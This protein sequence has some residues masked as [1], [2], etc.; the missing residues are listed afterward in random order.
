MLSSAY[1][2]YLTVYC[3]LFLLKFF[4]KANTFVC[5]VSYIYFSFVDVYVLWPVY[6]IELS[7]NRSS[8]KEKF[9]VSLYMYWYRSG[10][11]QHPDEVLSS[12][13]YYLKLLQLYSNMLATIF[14]LGLKWEIWRRGQRCSWTIDRDGRLL[15]WVGQSSVNFWT[16]TTIFIATGAALFCCY[17]WCWWWWWWWT[18]SRVVGSSVRRFDG[19]LVGCFE[20]GEEGQ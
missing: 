1:V 5:Y 19:W 13:Y 12:F 15:G 14:I 20:S 2:I 18:L 9:Q 4:N 11:I 3:T 17:W 7:K 10:C 6:Y 8:K 16:A